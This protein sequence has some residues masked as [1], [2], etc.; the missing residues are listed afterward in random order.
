MTN[1]SPNWRPCFTVIL[2]AVIYYLILTGNFMP[3]HAEKIDPELVPPEVTLP[4]TSPPGS[5]P[6]FKTQTSLD[7]SPANS[8]AHISSTKDPVAV[9]QTSKGTIVIRLFAKLAPNTAANFIEL[10]KK[11]FYNGLTFHRVEPG[12]VI[13][14]GCPNGNGSGLYIDPSTNK[15]R[16]LNLEINPNLRHNAPGVVAMANFGKN[17]NSASCQFYITLTAQPRLDNRYSIFG[18]VVDG[19]DVVNHIVVGDKIVSISIE[20]PKL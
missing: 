12:F 1:S 8:Q 2:M 11:G 7:K 4:L 15:P 18:G 20:E 6:T 14:G 3:A 19:M 9:M 17:P 16:F 13:Q 5:L 10:A